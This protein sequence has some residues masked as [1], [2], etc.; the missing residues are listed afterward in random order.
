MKKNIK[1]YPTREE[2]LSIL[3]SKGCSEQVINHILIVTDLA[4]KIA[5]YFPEADL[6]LLEAGALL[7]DLG[8]SE[9][10]GVDHAVCGSQLAS[11]LGI[12]EDVVKIIERHIAAG[13]PAADAEALGLPVK[14]YTPITIEER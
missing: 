8:R 7:H 14:D 3:K 4:L 6:E 9:S 10:H 11:Y 1:K 13:I 12:A 2:C 5:K